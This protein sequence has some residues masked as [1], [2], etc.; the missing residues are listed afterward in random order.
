[1]TTASLFVPHSLVEALSLRRE[2][3]SDLVVMG[4]GT[5]V[6]AQINDGL[7]FPRLVMSLARAALDGVRPDDDGGLE[8]GA[9]TSVA[10]LAGLDELP[11][12]RRA[13]EG[14]GGPALRTMAT[15]GGNL[16]AA[17]PYGDLAVPLLALDA[18]VEVAGASGRRRL[19]AEAFFELSLQPEELVVAVHVPRPRGRTAYLKLGRRAASSPSVV[20]VAV[21]VVEDENGICND[22]RVA[23]GAAGPRP[24]RAHE[25]ESMLVGSDLGGDAIAAA[26]QAA[27][28]A[29]DPPADALASAW[30]RREMVRV[31]VRRALE[32]ADEGV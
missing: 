13:A 31:M 22:A 14:L 32:A 15:L 17:P 1:M 11:L 3:G 20:A 28:Q 23:L 18:E 24:L 4:G 29:C 30:Y 7:R 6:M 2:H 19:P 12:L 27:Q 10:R 8:I 9:T 26:A 5:V 16:F 25:A 21:R